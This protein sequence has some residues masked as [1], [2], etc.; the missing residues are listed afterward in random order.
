[1]S[2]WI[3]IWLT[4]S[5]LHQHIQHH[6]TTV[7][8][9]LIRLSQGASTGCCPNKKGDPLRGL[10]TP[11]TL[12]GK[13]VSWCSSNSLVIRANSK[14]A[15]PLNKSNITMDQY[16][17]SPHYTNTYNT[18]QLWSNLNKIITSKEI[19]TSSCPKIKWETLLGAVAH[20]I[21]FQ[22]KELVSA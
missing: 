3:N 8:P 13:R 16:M 6:P 4:A 22:R 7:K 18:T 12:L 19:P 1:M 21:L 2:Q 14:D 10:S 17:V 20:Q 15:N 5:P 9:R 11:N